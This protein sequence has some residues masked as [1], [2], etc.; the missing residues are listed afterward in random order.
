[1]AGLRG[2]RDDLFPFL[3]GHAFRWAGNLG[4]SAAKMTVQHFGIWSDAADA[5]LTRLS[6][7]SRIRNGHVTVG[8]PG[9]RRPRGT[10]PSHF[11]EHSLSPK[12]PTDVAPSWDALLRPLGNTPTSKG[13]TSTLGTVVRPRPSSHPP[14]VIAHHGRMMYQGLGRQDLIAGSVLCERVSF[15]CSLASL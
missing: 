12:E 7:E 2:M 4:F 10:S 5:R 6:P 13:S 9:D 8:G 15:V 14:R 3:A 11:G 1:M